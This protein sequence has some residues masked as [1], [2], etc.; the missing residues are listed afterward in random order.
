MLFY[1]VSAVKIYD[2]QQMDRFITESESQYGFT[3]CQWISEVIIQSKVITLDCMTPD[4][5]KRFIHLDE[6]KTILSE[7]DP[8][9]VNYPQLK[10]KFSQLTGINQ[11][12]MSLTLYQGKS[13]YCV[14]TA[15]S[16]WLLNLN[17][18]SILWKVDKNDD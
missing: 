10:T 7:L 15:T 16:E 9:L 2:H 6:K 3:D 11:F 17:D 4:L 1:H 12:T 14:T 18:Y 5:G 8:A 13:V